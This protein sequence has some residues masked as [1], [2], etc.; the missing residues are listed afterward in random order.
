MTRKNWATA[1]P[2][3]L[4]AVVVVFLMIGLH[5][6]TPASKFAQHVGEPV[7]VTDLPLLDTPAAHFTT[8]GW[9]GQP[10]II[11]FFASWC[12]DCRA[13]HEELMTL[14][15]GHLPIIGIGF[16]DKPE[17]ISTYL[18]HEGNPFVAVALDE[19]GRAGIDWGLTGVPETLVID[20][21]GVI[22]W[23]HIGGLDDDI[24]TRALM[25]LWLSL[26]SEGDKGRTP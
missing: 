3:I 18:T 23:H 25:P 10:Y 14:A 5:R 8:A 19:K 20:A 6:G 13:E 2:L 22:R 12:A 24:V 7:P 11:N 16:K 17:K 26:Q 15:A 21:Q 9:H 1:I 4:F